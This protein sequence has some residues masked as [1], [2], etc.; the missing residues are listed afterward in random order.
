VVT[1][2]T[3][4]IGGKRNITS[5]RPALPRQLHDHIPVVFLCRTAGFLID[6]H[7]GNYSKFEHDK[8]E[9]VRG[10]VVHKTNGTGLDVRSPSNVEANQ[11]FVFVGTFEQNML[12]TKMA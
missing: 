5:P 6:F 12:R 11:G 1:T 2:S 4:R 8:Q 9:D 10:I 7:S 3:T